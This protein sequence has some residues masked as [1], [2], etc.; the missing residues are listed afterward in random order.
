MAKEQKNY[1]TISQ[2]VK[3]FRKYYPDLTSSKL[4]FLESRGLIIPKRAENKYRVYF[5]NDVNKINLILKLQKEYF[6]PL[7]VIREKINTV[8]FDKISSTGGQTEDLRQLQIK[9]QESDRNIKVKKLTPEEI[10]NKYKISNEDMSELIDDGIITFHEEDG[11]NVI[12]GADIE[13]LKVIMNLA[14]F[15]IHT[16]HLKLFENTALRQSDFLQ[17]II[18]PLMM[19]KNRDAHKKASRIF[20]RLEALFIEFHELLFKRENKK[21]LDDHK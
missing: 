13:I 3:K 15:G 5:K 4:R 16:K 17:Q 20:Y 2:L 21:F 12:D 9:L 10:S 7:E 18:Y 14:N 6:M 19:S 8:D 1:L 11:K